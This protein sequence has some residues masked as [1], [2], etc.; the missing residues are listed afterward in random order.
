MS[1]STDSIAQNVAQVTS[2]III[3]KTVLDMFNKFKFKKGEK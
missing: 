3:G 1:S 2:P